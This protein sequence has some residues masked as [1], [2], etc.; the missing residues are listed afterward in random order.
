MHRINV[1]LVNFSNLIFED[2][3]S[4]WA[5]ERK[6]LAILMIVCLCERVHH[7]SVTVTSESYGKIINTYNGVCALRYLR[8]DRVLVVGHF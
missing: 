4:R 8:L 2:C 7:M 3:Q 1:W 5:E 6:P